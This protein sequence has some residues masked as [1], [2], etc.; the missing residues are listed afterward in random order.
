MTAEAANYKITT[1][2]QLLPS[3]ITAIKTS[4]VN[5]HP[6]T[7]TF[8]SDYNFYNATPGYIWSSRGTLMGPHAVTI[9]GYDDSKH[10]YKVINSWTAVWGD[11]GCTWID[12][13]FFTTISGYVYSM[14]L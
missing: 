11:Q 10:A 3:D 1:Y 2:Q 13:T 9:I 7:F 12:Y 4:I 6:L 14:T 8:T 5:K